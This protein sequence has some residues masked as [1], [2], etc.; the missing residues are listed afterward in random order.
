MIAKKGVPFF[1]A[2]TFAPVHGG[3]CKVEVVADTARLAAGQTSQ[4]QVQWGCEMKYQGR[5]N[6][7]LA[8]RCP[9]P[10]RGNFRVKK[11][12]NRGEYLVLL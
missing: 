9:G 2:A 1:A 3:W 7:N 11:L 10:P 8:V 6:S 4:L 12:Y 5:L